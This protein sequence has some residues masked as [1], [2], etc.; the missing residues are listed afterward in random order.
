MAF[1]GD[2]PLLIYI[3]ERIVQKTEVQRCLLAHFKPPKRRHTA[4]WPWTNISAYLVWKT[5]KFLQQDFCQ[6]LNLLIYTGIWVLLH[7][8]RCAGL[9]YTSLVLPEFNKTS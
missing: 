9:I 3:T 8:A 4:A 6:W 7:C 2:L 5:C 1:K